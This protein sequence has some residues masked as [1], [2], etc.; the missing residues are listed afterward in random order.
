MDTLPSGTVTFLFTDIEAS[1][2]L[3]EEHPEEM[4]MALARHDEVVR[5]AVDAFDGFVFSAAGDGFA[6]AFRRAGDGVGAAVGHSGRCRVNPGLIR[7]CCGCAWVCIPGKPKSVTQLFR[8]GSKRGGKVDGVHAGG[9]VVVSS[10]TA[11]LAVVAGVE[12]V[13][14]GAVRLRGLVDPTQV[15]GVCVE[16]SDRSFV[17]RRERSYRGELAVPGDGV[18]RADR[19]GA[20]GIGEFGEASPCHV[21]RAGRGGKDASG[22]RGGV[23]GDR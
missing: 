1:T 4:R 3:W 17:C 14:L 9:Q 5:K 6:A 7:W 23:V 2:R 20:S 11:A 8:F 19:C 18:V 22:G 21:H 16:G 15:F 13:D 10:L 12:L